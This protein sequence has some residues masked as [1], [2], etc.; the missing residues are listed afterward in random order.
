MRHQ[1][2]GQ[3]RFS[4]KLLPDTLHFIPLHSR[5]LVDDGYWKRFTL[6]GQSLGSI[7][8]VW[9]GLTGTDGFWGDIFV[10]EQLGAKLVL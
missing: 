3:D 8:L 1:S 6:L 10:G 7:W 5:Y 2:D 9:Q 4:I